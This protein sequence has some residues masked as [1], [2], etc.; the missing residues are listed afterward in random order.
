MIF[1]SYLYLS[2]DA[3]FTKLLQYVKSCQETEFIQVFDS[4]GYV[5]KE[6]IV[7][8]NDLPQY[9]SSHM[10]GFALKSI[11]TYNASESNPISF[12]ISRIRSILGNQPTDLLK[13]GR[14]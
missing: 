13:P 12:I 14:H 3:A 6:D 7:S 11:E 10:D 5:L 4:R 2:V 1:D 9:P 8:K